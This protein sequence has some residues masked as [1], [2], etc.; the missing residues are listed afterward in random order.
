[1]GSNSGPVQMPK[2]KVISRRWR[3]LRKLGEGGCGA[4]YKVEDLQTKKEAALKAES[5]FVSGGSVLKLEVQI[6]RRLTNK[7]YVAQLL[8]SGKRESYSYIVMTLLGESLRHIT[9]R[10][11]R[12][13]SVS[14][15]V[16]IGINVLFGLKQIHDNRLRAPYVD[17]VLL[18][19][20]EKEKTVSA[21]AESLC[22]NSAT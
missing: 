7:P 18:L 11:G 22:I 5:N 2:G 6:L 3:I 12:I 15:Q 14:T 20:R 10:L 16:R 4:V 13:F 17:V 1:M 9:K 19:E 8:H 21:N